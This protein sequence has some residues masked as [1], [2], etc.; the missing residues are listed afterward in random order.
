M[1]RD[2]NSARRPVLFVFNGGPISPSVPFTSAPSVRAAWRF[3][4]TS[5]RTSRTLPLVDNVDAPLDVADV[6][7]FDPANTGFSRTLPGVPAGD[8]FFGGRRRTPAGPAGA[9]MERA[10]T[11]GQ[12]SPKYLVG[13]SYGSCARAEAAEQ[14]QRSDMPL[15]GVMLFGQALNII[16]Y[17]QR[18]GNTISYAVSLPTLAALAWSH[19]RARRRGRSFDRFIRDAQAYGDGEYLTVLYLGDRAP[20]ARRQAVARRLEEFTG[21]SA[22]LYLERNLRISKA[23]Y[24]R[25]LF[26]GYALNSYDGRY[27]YPEA[28]PPAPDEIRIG[29]VYEPAFRRYLVEELHVG[30]IEEYSFAN[31]FRGG[32]NDWDWGPNESPFGDWP[33]VAQISRVMQQN[34]DFRV[35][36]GNGY[37]RHPDDD[38]RDGLYG[39][40]LGL[41]ARSRAHLLL[42]WRPHVLRNRD[43]PAA[44]DAR[45]PCDGDAS[46]VTRGGRLGEER[47]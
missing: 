41:A 14:L 7:I 27:R 30:N 9:R 24:L 16:E 26:P 31:P 18:P 39:F 12:A 15:D 19:D 35:L 3:R 21:L 45:H 17:A 5:T 25:L 32:L 4:T 22:A 20:L 2:V 11:A 6:V 8:L 10:G 47:R 42:S 46:V 36:V 43:R 13:T 28:P 23:D 37:Y 38:R 1:P 34:P 29:G 40:E 44:D 33:C